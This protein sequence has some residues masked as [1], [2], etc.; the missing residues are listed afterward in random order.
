MLCYAMFSLEVKAGIS[1][2]QQSVRVLQTLV[3]MMFCLTQ[4]SLPHFDHF[5]FHIQR[6]VGF[7]SHS[8]AV[9]PTS[10]PALWVTVSIDSCRIKAQLQIQYDHFNRHLSSQNKIHHCGRPFHSTA[11]ESKPKST[12]NMITSIDTCRTKIKSIIAGY[13]FTQQLSGQSLN[14]HPIW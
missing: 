13:P 9:E 14:P 6:R 1:P 12:S 10:N 2:I 7:A 5:L 11:A 3:L 4:I 8:T